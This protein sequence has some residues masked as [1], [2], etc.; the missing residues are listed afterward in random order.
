M[1]KSLSK[2]ELDTYLPQKIKKN[3][4]NR[5]EE[6]PAFAAWLRLKHIFIAEINPKFIKTN[7]IPM[8]SRLI[9]RAQGFLQRMVRTTAIAT[10][11]RGRS[12][13]MEI[14]R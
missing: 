8:A 11:E 13:S 3:G 4:K 10:F 12:K 7:K 5:M 1:T 9:W 6:A 2:K 14:S